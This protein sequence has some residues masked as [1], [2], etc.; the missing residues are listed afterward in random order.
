VEVPDPLADPV[1]QVDPDPP[2]PD[3]PD[4]DDPE[5]LA[6]PTVFTVSAAPPPQALISRSK[7]PAKTLVRIATIRRSGIMTLVQPTL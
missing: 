3:E 7:V 5:P 6:L 4:P 1:P 2:A